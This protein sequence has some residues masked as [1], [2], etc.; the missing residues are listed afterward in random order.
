[1][2]IMDIMLK[3][4]AYLKMEWVKS[5][6]LLQGSLS[7]MVLFDFTDLALEILVLYIVCIL[8]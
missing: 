7:L 1:M 4:V 3:F 6:C 8:S 5:I 2:E